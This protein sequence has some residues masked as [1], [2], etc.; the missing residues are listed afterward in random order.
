MPMDKT[1]TDK[2]NEKFMKM[3]APQ[4]SPVPL[5]T[6]T[7]REVELEAKLAAATKQLEEYG[8]WYEDARSHIETVTNT[9]RHIGADNRIAVR[10]PLPADCPECGYTHS[11][12][13]MSDNLR[14]RFRH[15]RMDTCSRSMTEFFRPIAQF[16]EFI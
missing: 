9:F 11:V 16:I 10:L 3:V 8:K 6:R 5:P 15:G 13:K 4:F 7:N 2:E 12:E 14:F 1:L